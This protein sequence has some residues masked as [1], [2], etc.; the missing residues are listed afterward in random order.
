MSVNLHLLLKVGGYHPSRANA[1]KQAIQAVLVNEQI[2]SDMSP[3]AESGEG[4]SSA[5]AA[6]SNPELPVSISGA[7]RWLPKVKRLLS[8]A[9]ENANG[10]PCIVVFDGFN[11]DKPGANTA[12]SDFLRTVDMNPLKPSVE[13]AAIV[14]AAPQI[15]SDV[16]EKLWE[17]IKAH[18]LQNPENKSIILCDAKLRAVLGKPEV[19][20]FELTG[21]AGKHLS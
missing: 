21:L 13:L 17:Y 18:N 7:G 10:G 1:I 9:A 3:L 19:S 14:G 16:I 12:A 20:L 6:R 2:N 4:A 15:R 5:I 8:K 11:A